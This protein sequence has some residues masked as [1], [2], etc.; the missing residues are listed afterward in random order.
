MTAVA[1]PPSVQ[2]GPRLGWHPAVDGGQGTLAPSNSDE[3]LRMFMP[4]KSVQRANSSS[5]LNSN[6]SS[7]STIIA[8]S[9]HSNANHASNESGSAASKK[10][11][12][13]YSWSN[14]KAEPVSGVTNAR[15]QPVSITPSGTSAS[16]AMS[17]LHQPTPVAP[18]Q[19]ALQNQ[20]QN[21]SR[22]TN[23]ALPSDPPAILTL[24]P[25]N[26]TFERKQITVPYFPEVLRV[27]RQTNAKT[28]PTPVNGYFDSKVLSRQHAEV[29]A[30]RAGKIWI[31]DVKSS[32]GTF[33]NGQRLSPEN[34]DS[35]PHE[36]REHDTLELGIDIVSEDQKS[37]VHHKV[38]AKVEHAGIYGPNMN[39]LDLSFG[40][41]DPTAGGGLLPSHLSLPLSHMRG[42]PGS[43][44]SVGSNRSNQSAAGNH[45]GILHQQR[46]MNYW[47][48]PISIEQV[49]KRLSSEMKQAKQQA[50]DLNQTNNFLS[51]L[52]SHD[53]LE[54]E[55]AKH[56]P[57]ESQ[58]GGRLVNG[59]PK[60]PKVDQ[61]SRFSDPPAPP[62]QQPLPEKPDAPPRTNSDSMPQPSLKRSDTEKPKA[63]IRSSANRESS[64]I[65]SLIEALASAKKD[66]DAQ[67]ARVKE[68]ENLLLTE[69]AAR[70]QAEERAR[71]LEGSASEQKADSEVV[72][73]CEPHSTSE[74]G[75]TVVVEEVS[76]VEPSEPEES[77]LSS[78]STLPQQSKTSSDAISQQLQQR[79]DS[80]IAEMD[81]MRKQVA[82]YKQSAEKAENEAFESRKTLGEMIEQIRRTQTETSASSSSEAIKIGLDDTHTE[83]D[84]L[85]D[86]LNERLAQAKGPQN[87][88]STSHHLDQAS[89]EV[90]G[91]YVKQRHKNM[92]DHSAPYASMLGVVLLGVGIMAYL[93]GWQRGDK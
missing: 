1:S 76:L 10:K 3:G 49:V 9:Q 32:N 5:S 28:V 81:E 78:D 93:N 30:D 39:I 66:L 43:A 15:S 25:V 2:S 69:R 44:A 87:T 40:D 21:G 64:Q 82:K 79:L 45:V 7:T 46:Q 72:A 35:E 19:H 27:G 37:I 17:A 34:R 16:S 53:I 56:S 14:S 20:Q 55:R 75:A 24:L 52:V 60:M 61:I 54:K 73:V 22:L 26:G 71:N 42:R 41:I 18:S 74:N 67:G 50:H 57:T 86:I 80:M 11:P 58:G 83:G 38:S 77:N 23:G 92:L 13:K 88:S 51:H 70:E 12:Y 29:W 8:N 6:S 48:S 59:R 90:Y 62:P 63:P 91:A 33:V 65:L 36:L 68:L 89:K 84:T 85:V 31:R 4:R 47:L